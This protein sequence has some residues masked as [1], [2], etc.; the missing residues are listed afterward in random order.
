MQES[1]TLAKDTRDDGEDVKAD[2]KGETTPN[3]VSTRLSFRVKVDLFRPWRLLRCIGGNE[4]GTG[5][6]LGVGGCGLWC[7]LLRDWRPVLGIRILAGRF[8]SDVTRF[9][10]SS[11]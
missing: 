11:V 6:G 9:R 1:Q 7:Y 8:F 2:P 4:T 10:D 5:R 3:V